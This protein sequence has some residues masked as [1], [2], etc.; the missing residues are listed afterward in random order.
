MGL[1][2]SSFILEGEASSGLPLIYFSS[3]ESI[4]SIEDST[5][6]ILSTGTVTI[7]ATQ[8]GNF[9]YEPAEPVEQT[10]IIYNDLTGITEIAEGLVV[11]PNPTYDVITIDNKS[12]IIN[13]IQLTDISG[14]V[15][16]TWDNVNQ[17]KLEIEIPA[18]KGLF[19]LKVSTK[20]GN[21]SNYR[22]IKID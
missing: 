15:L 8:P 11:F 19:L 18:K 3:D 22:I 20:K 17:T 1:S 14:K 6:I 12:G 16:N 2:V 4:I 21:Q 7:T 9:E 5:A 10:I 13:T